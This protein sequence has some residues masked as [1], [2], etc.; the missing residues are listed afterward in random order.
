[1]AKEKA[2][3]KCKNGRTAVWHSPVEVVNGLFIVVQGA[4]VRAGERVK[5]F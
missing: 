2:H 3:C 1:V 4:V 5:P